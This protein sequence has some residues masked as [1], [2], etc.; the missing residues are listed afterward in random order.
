MDSV[1]FYFGVPEFLPL[2]TL[3]LSS[4]GRVVM[5][6]NVVAPPLLAPLVAAGLLSLPRVWM[7]SSPS[8]SSPTILCVREF[9]TGG[10]GKIDKEGSEAFG[11]WAFSDIMEL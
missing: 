1:V 7:R 3:Y 9:Q 11:E 6:G 2:T 4:F 5:L 10:G 8:A